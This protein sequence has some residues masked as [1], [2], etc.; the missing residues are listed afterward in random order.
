MNCKKNWSVVDI[1]LMLSFSAMVHPKMSKRP[2]FS[3]AALLV[4][5]SRKKTRGGEQPT[6]PMWRFLFR[7]CTPLNAKEPRISAL[8]STS[9]Q[10][11]ATWRQVLRSGGLSCTTSKAKHSL[12][13]SMT[14]LMLWAAYAFIPQQPC[15][16]SALGRDTSTSIRMMDQTATAVLTVLSKTTALVGFLAHPHV[17]R[18]V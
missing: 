8:P 16:P 6:N 1:L 7:R 9:I 15:W 17:C 3:G 4:R 13:H 11:G 14:R 10:V 2:Q 12:V 18:T 5:Y